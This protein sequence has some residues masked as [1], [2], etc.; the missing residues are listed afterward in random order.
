[1]KKEP[2][3][4]PEPATTIAALEDACD[5]LSLDSIAHLFDRL[6]SKIHACVAARNWVHPVS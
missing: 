6:H 5:S 2:T 4:S 1:M 3:L